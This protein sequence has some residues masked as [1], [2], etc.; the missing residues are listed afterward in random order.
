MK[1]S[2]FVTISAATVLVLAGCGGGNA[3]TDT[4]TTPA[5]DTTTA[6]ADTPTDTATD[7]TDAS[8]PAD[9]GS[10][11]GSGEAAFSVDE[12]CEGI[13]GGGDN[14]LA[15]RLPTIIEKWE[16]GVSASEA[17]QAWLINLTLSNYGKAAPEPLATHIEALG[18]PFAQIAQAKDAGEEEITADGS[19][20]LDSLE[21]VKTECEAA[22]YTVTP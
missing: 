12:I 16:D 6:S 14:A 9:N 8:D 13:F 11:A 1:R 5:T 21:Q 4:G 15:T 22:G 10:D 19:N 3:T 18:A 2:F 20:V 7:A 17:S